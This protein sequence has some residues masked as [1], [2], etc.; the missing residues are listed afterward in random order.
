MKPNRYLF[1]V[2][3]I[4]WFIFGGIAIKNGL[5]GSNDS[6]VFGLGIFIS[7]LV[8]LAI[9]LFVI[10]CDDKRDSFFGVDFCPYC[11]SQS[12]NIKEKLKSAPN[13]RNSNSYCHDC[14]S[15]L[16]LH[17]SYY[18]LGL[19]GMLSPLSMLFLF[20]SE[21]AMFIVLCATMPIVLWIYAKHIPVVKI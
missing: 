19:A 20:D 4:A 18:F 9:G 11:G 3:F 14:G 15:K 12:I 7:S 17:Y 21:A 10:Y 2:L 6:F 16:Q 1:F 13:E 8:F 5:V